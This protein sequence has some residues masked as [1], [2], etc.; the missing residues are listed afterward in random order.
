MQTINIGKNDAG[1]RA[2]KFL[3]KYLSLAPKGFL[4]KMMR[5]KNI[6]LNKKK[7]SG[8]E[9]LKPGDQIQMFLS[10]ETIQKFSNRNDT[11]FLN[12]EAH[13]FSGKFQVLYED[14]DVLFLNKPCGVLS[15]KADPGDTSLVEYLTAYLL[16]TGSIADADLRCFH[17][18]VC[19]RLDR[20][21]S[22]IVTA[23]KSLKGLQGLSELLKR[24]TLRKYYRTIVCGQFKE[25][26]RAGGFLKKDEIRN[27]VTI[28]T[29][30]CPGSI[31]IET[32]YLPIYIG[33]EFTLLEVHLITGR[34]HQIR[35]HLASLG[36]PIIGD[37]KYGHRSVNEKLKKEFGLNHQLLHAYRMEFPQDTGLLTN[38]S[39]KIICAQL[40]RQFQQILTSMENKRGA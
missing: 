33:K 6:T 26:V 20:N 22:G 24:R 37:Y 23:G 40:P 38:L 7:M 18:S 27:K 5:K 29:E 36:F 31:P 2:D 1:Q 3:A 19:N 39:G 35:A 11:S 30:A 10:D 4:Y 12:S 16:E 14:D 9:H 15:Q 25:S 13:N 32:E 28:S 34:T 8:N 21:T 17:P